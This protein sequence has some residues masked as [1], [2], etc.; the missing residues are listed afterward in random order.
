[1]ATAPTSAALTSRRRWPP[2]LIAALLLTAAV[3]L[4]FLARDN[5]LS[6]DEAVTGIMAQKIAAGVRLFPY[7][8]GQN[9]NSAVE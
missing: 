1:M 3:R 2:D 7:F 8:A 9:Y 5:A 4:V 6:G